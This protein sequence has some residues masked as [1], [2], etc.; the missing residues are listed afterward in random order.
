VKSLFAATILV[1]ALVVLFGSPI[2]S[3][4]PVLDHYYDAPKKIL[5]MSFAHLD[6]VP[7][8]CVDCHHNYVDDSGGGL[9]MT[10]H[11]TD[12]AVWPLLEN[13]FHDLCRGCHEEKAALGEAGG[14]PRE[15]M[16]CHLGDDLP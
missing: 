10:C 16:A 9:C 11:V 3:E 4:K 2:A 13:Q 14:P 5:P 8:N 12:Q 15:C 1:G 6:H 7:V